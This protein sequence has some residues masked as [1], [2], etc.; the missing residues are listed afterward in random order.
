MT[1][2]QSSLRFTFK[3]NGQQ[4]YKYARTTRIPGG[5]QLR[6]K[7]PELYA[8]GQW[9]AYFQRA[10]GIDIWDVDNCHYRDWSS[11]GIGATLLGYRH[12]EVT[13]AVRRCIDAGSFSLLN[14]SEDVE[15]ADL[16]CELHPWAECARFARSGGEI[17]T[18]AIRI[19]RATTGRSKV[20]ICGYHGWHDWYLA[21]NLDGNDRLRFHLLAGIEPKGIPPQLA[22]TAHCFELNDTAGFDA[23]INEHGDDLACIVMEPCR[24][25]DPDPGFLQHV[26]EQASR[27][28][29]LLLFDEITIGF[30]RHLG[31]S[32]LRLGVT[33]DIAIFAKSL[34]NGHPMAALI[35]TAEAMDGAHESFI[36]STYWTERVGPTAA[37][38]TIKVMQHT[39]V[40]QHIDRIGT[41]IKTCWTRH[42]EATK[43]PL[44][45]SGGFNC[46]AIFTF[47]HELADHL[48]LFYIQE[49]LKRGFLATNAIYV[50]LAHTEENLAAYDVAVG[51]V[52]AEMADALQAGDLEGR[53]DGPLAVKGFGRL[54]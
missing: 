18:V 52:F 24:F 8:P 50:S 28:G 10:E 35:G 20:A 16:L 15:L 48:R 6:S 13:G 4:L 1:P 44:A 54:T 25:E 11:H 37:L 3:M 41:K 21:A 33:P 22:G 7:V 53:L 51:D 46:F 2:Q 26:R 29:S 38:A 9:P 17:T 40:P 5:S 43:V 47:E 23:L 30:R 36:S 27:T 39:D 49:M 42:I 12:P 45:V 34:G 19:A 32:H 14:S 31:G